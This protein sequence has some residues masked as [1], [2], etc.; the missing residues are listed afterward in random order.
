[1]KK[2]LIVLL[3]LV[4][5]IITLIAFINAIRYPIQ[6][7]IESNDV[8][9]AKIIFYGDGIDGEITKQKDVKKLI[10][11]LNKLRFK[12]TENMSHL[13]PH[14][15]IL[16]VELYD[17]NDKCIDCI[18]FYDWAYRGG[19]YKVEE[20]KDGTYL[21]VKRGIHLGDLYALCD[22]LCGNPFFKGIYNIY[23][24]LN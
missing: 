3:G 24:Y 2:R 10:R 11:T 12:E 4:I 6:L 21:S 1:M 17:D 13:F 14:S 19:E 15:G 7:K 20:R 18:Q 9:T 8:K 16:I 5:G 22:K 23:H